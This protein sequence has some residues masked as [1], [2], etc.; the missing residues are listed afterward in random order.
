MQQTVRLEDVVY[1]GWPQIPPGS[2]LQAKIRSAAT[3]ADCTAV[4]VEGDNGQ[5][6]VLFDQPVF[7]PA[8]GQSCVLYEGERIIAGGLVKERAL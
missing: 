4:T 7:A 6:D 1:A 5:I 2:R 8:P 3:P